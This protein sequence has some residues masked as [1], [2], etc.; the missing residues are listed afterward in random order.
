MSIHLS[1]EFGY[2]K[3]TV[4]Q[5]DRKKT[6]TITTIAM[7]TNAAE[8]AENEDHDEKYKSVASRVQYP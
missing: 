6:K 2:L 5:C 8:N 1:N 3:G 7:L 4:C